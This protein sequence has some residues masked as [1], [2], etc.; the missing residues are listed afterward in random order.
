[1]EFLVN[2]LLIS[3]VFLIFHI[4]SKN[5]S[6]FCFAQ[7][8]KNFWSTCSAWSILNLTLIHPII[9]ALIVQEFLVP[10]LVVK[11]YF[12]FQVFAILFCISKIKRGGHFIEKYYPLF[13][14][15]F[16]KVIWFINYN[17]HCFNSI[18]I[19]LVLVNKFFCEILFCKLV[20]IY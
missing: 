12:L 4:K 17:F 9:I 18:Y 19:Q 10:F 7:F 3:L 15:L 13:L 1:M 16:Y 20:L 6:H 8:Y 11:L 14:Q 2:L 5:K